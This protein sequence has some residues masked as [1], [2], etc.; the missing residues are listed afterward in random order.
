ML[1]VSNNFRF[2]NKREGDVDLLVNYEQKYNYKVVKP[3]PL[4]IDK[5]IPFINPY[6]LKDSI[7]YS[8]QVGIK[9]QFEPNIGDI[10]S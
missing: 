8:E 7:A 2:G 6:S 9:R 1:F 10:I 5:K 3:K 4:F